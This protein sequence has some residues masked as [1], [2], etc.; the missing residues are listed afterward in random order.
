MAA[1]GV[2]RDIRLVLYLISEETGDQRVRDL[3]KVTASSGNRPGPWS[4]ALPLGSSLC[5]RPPRHSRCWAPPAELRLWETLATS[6]SE[7]ALGL[8]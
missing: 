2:R 8:S 5:R 1:P 4:P 6:E 3:P 7:G